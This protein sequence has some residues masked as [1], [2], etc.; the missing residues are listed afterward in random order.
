M[1][2]V[3]F[4]AIKAVKFKINKESCESEKKLLCELITIETVVIHTLQMQ[5]RTHNAV[6]KKGLACYHN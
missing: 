1:F 2:K 3:H 4:E 6:V 5:K